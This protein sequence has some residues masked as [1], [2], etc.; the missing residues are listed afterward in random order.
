MAT[1]TLHLPLASNFAFV[2]AIITDRKPKSG[3]TPTTLVQITVAD[4]HCPT[5]KLC[6]SCSRNSKPTAAR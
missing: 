6:A 2:N 5:K 1:A 4:K 3:L